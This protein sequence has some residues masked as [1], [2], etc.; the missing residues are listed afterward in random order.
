MDLPVAQTFRMVYWRSQRRWE[1][2]R[3]G[4]TWNPH[5]HHAIFS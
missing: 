3:Y 4:C 2:R 5:I 1:K